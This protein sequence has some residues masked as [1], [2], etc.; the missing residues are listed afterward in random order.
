MSQQTNKLEY[1]RAYPKHKVEPTL[2]VFRA[3]VANREPRDVLALGKEYNL[4]LTVFESSGGYEENGQ[5]LVEESITFETAAYTSD[6]FRA[7]V[8]RLLNFGPVEN[9]AYFTVDGKNPV[10]ITRNGREKAIDN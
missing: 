10:L 9:F 8:V 5:Y 4:A 1:P 7:V 3:V 6:N 2:T